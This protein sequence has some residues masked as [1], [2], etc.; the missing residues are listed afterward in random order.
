[1]EDKAVRGGWINDLVE[2]GLD[3]IEIEEPPKIEP[4]EVLLYKNSGTNPIY[5]DFTEQAIQ[6]DPE[7]FP[8]MQDFEIQAYPEM[9]IAEVQTLVELLDKEME[10]D[11]GPEMTDNNTMVDIEVEERASS[12][13]FEWPEVKEEVEVTSQGS[14]PINLGVDEGSQV[15]IRREVEDK[16][17]DA[18]MMEGVDEGVQSMQE[19]RDEYTG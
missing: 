1:M 7:I 9:M 17:S 2:I 3:P 16:G 11:K 18:V 19:V 4:L 12:P 14:D 8:E 6:S 10:T 5:P 15:E 13:V